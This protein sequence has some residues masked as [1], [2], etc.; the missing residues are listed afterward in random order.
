MIN[1]SGRVQRVRLGDDVVSRC[2][3]CKDERNHQIEAL[4]SGGNIERVTC[5]T[6][7]STHLH[8]G[9]RAEAKKSDAAKRQPASPV[10][11]ATARIVRPARSYSPGET[12]TVGDVIDHSKFGFGEVMDVRSGKIEVKFGG[13]RRTLIHKH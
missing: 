9:Q 13:E 10:G 11:S 8:R 6:C 7:R 4:D 2:G 3:R 1:T 12:F 5:K